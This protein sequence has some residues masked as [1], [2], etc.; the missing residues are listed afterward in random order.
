MQVSSL[1]RLTTLE[2]SLVVVSSIA[3]AQTNPPFAT[4]LATATQVR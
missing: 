3:V 4:R 1:P 2:V